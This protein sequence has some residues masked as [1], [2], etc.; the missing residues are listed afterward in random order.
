MPEKWPAAYARLRE[1]ADES[2][3]D[4]AL[5]LSLVF[6]D[7][8]AIQSLIEQAE[9][10]KAL[11]EV[12]RRAI[13]ALAARRTSGFDTQL[14]ALARDAAT[15]RAAV[16]GLAAYSH[17]DT[18]ATILAIYATA[19]S[20]T[21]QDALATLAARPAWARALVDAVEAGRIERREITAFTARQ[22][23]S[24]GD[25]QLSARIQKLWGQIREAPRER[26]RLIAD[27]KR[28]LTPEAITTADRHRGRA[29]FDKH[30]ANCHR[31]FDA[32]TAIGPDL[33]GAQRNNVDYLLLNLIDPGSSISIEF[34]MQ[35]IE[36]IDGRV[37]SGLVIA[38]SDNAITVQTANEK[39]V[40]PAVEV[41]RREQSGGSMMPEGLLQHLSSD[42]VRDLFAYLMGG[43]QTTPSTDKD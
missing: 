38:E 26:T 23:H 31:L 27:Y 5:R 32:G 22:I 17:P 2:I 28:R 36:T 30:C 40:I 18:A 34:R 15:S 37:V 21:R 16:R 7:P 12:R 3:R 43:D 4:L 29:I 41:E 35:V 13:D 24:L 10:R 6:D 25:K 8:V 42:E 11:A 14:L 1:S 19:D 39:V 9:D 33:T 20:P